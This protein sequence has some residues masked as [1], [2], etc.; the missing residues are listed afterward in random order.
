MENTLGMLIY[1]QNLFKKSNW[2][3][4]PDDLVTFCEE[5]ILSIPLFF[6][7]NFVLNL[8]NITQ[9]FQ[10]LLLWVEYQP[11]LFLNDQKFKTY[12]IDM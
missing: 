6:S 3:M 7:T 5:W 8:H 2:F 12:E 11:A 4:L 10:D 9:T 1:I